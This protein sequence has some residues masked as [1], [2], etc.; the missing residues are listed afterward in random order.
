[1]CPVAS[2]AGFQCGDVAGGCHSK[3]HVDNEVEEWGKEAVVVGEVGIVS[4]L[5][6]AVLM[7]EVAKDDEFG[8][9]VC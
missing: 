4:A 2:A 6:G 5:P 9:G 3:W 7:V 1:V 8:V